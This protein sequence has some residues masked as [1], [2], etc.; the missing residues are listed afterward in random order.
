MKIGLGQIQICWE[1]RGKPPESG[2]VY[3]PFAE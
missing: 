2:T 3:E 1:D